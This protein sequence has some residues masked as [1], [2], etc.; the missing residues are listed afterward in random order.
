MATR[1]AK[2]FDEERDGVGEVVGGDVGVAT[3]A[4]GGQHQTPC[5]TTGG[6]G[7][8]REGSRLRV[9]GLLETMS[10]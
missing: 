9:L 3:E 2:D 10:P 8:H 4:E 1:G 5:G 6:L 7:G